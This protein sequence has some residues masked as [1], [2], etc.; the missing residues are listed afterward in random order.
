MK[1]IAIVILLFVI[2]STLLIGCTPSVLSTPRNVRIDNELLK[3][4]SVE[5]ATGY[6]I[7]V[8]GD[9]MAET[10]NTTYKLSEL[11]LT[12]GETYEITVAA[13]G[14]GYL[15]TQSSPSE[16]ITYTPN[17]LVEEAK[18]DSPSRPIGEAKAVTDNDLA[19]DLFRSGLGYGVNALTATSAVGGTRASAFFN[20]SLID[21]D[22]L[23]GYEIGMSESKAITATNIK[24]E[25]VKVNSK[26]T[27]GTATELSY[28]G[29]F[30]GGFEER[31][32]LSTAIE[33][34]VHQNQFYF[35]LNMN[36][37][38]KIYQLKNYQTSRAYS[39]KLSQY[40]LE[41][42][43]DLRAGTMTPASFFARYGT[44]LMMAV[45]Y[46]GKIEVNYA[47]FSKEA[48]NSSKIAT[49]LEMKLRAGA[50]I[51]AIDA[52]TSTDFGTDLESDQSQSQ[53]DTFTSL[54]I[55]SISKQPQTSLT[56]SDFS[57][58]Y[59]AWSEQLNDESNFR[60]IDIADGGLVPIWLYIPNEYS[61]VVTILENYFYEEATERGLAL[62]NKLA[63]IAQEEDK[64]DL[65]HFNGG[66]GTIESPY[67]ITSK[68]HFINMMN[69]E[70]SKNYFSL[71]QDIDLKDWSDYGIYNWAANKST[72]PKSFKGYFNG[73]NHTVTYSIRI[74]KTTNISWALGL[75]PCIESAEIKNLN[76]ACTITTYDPQNRKKKWDISNDDRAMDVMVGG[77]VGYAKNS[78]IKACSTSGE[79]HYNSDGGTND[80]S[81]GGVIGFAKNCNEDNKITDCSSSTNIYVR[82]CWIELGGVI[83]LIYK[84]DY[85]NL[86]FTGSRK[87]NEDWA[88]T[89]GTWS[90]DLVGRSGTD[91][92]PN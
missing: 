89:G 54:K 71:M 21:K 86:K 28:A 25:A 41:D 26:I 72:P 24:D 90:N 87:S 67:L 4:N 83:G 9:E 65:V 20:E 5:G 38:G 40:V 15:K 63:P 31:F 23:S 80:T 49:S 10:T 52:S 92:L 48:I 18:E 12:E 62:I 22:S 33:S 30:S 75:F 35:I 61:D 45:C 51:G 50:S 74:G 34:K 59:A 19:S 7:F 36:N 79:I 81:V 91:I 3:W 60:I 64:G 17:T 46:G 85:S 29:M 16:K 8:N 44:H 84:T 58:N 66:H 6:K 77:I 27:Y 11:D 13:K 37:T 69:W 42:L 78:T 88:F 2:I 73:N 53:N 56:F 70:K 47:T 43:A 14:D 1:K 39:D 76:A 55:H 68:E 82:G 57:G 32:S